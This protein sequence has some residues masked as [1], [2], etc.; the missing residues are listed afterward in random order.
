M[1]PNEN[2]V[3]P[4]RIFQMAWGYAPPLILEAAIRHRI[5]DMLDGGPKSLSQLQK[6]TGASERGLSA[7][8][9]ALVALNLLSKDGQGRF[10]LTPESAA[11]LVSSKPSF[12]GGLLRHTSQDLIPKWLQLNEIVATG[13]PAQ[14]VNQK[15]AGIEFFRKFVNDIFPMSYP[16]AQ[17][18]ARH[19]ETEG[20]RGAVRVL[21]LGAGS[22]VWGIGLAQGSADL[23]VTALDWPDVIQVTRETVARFGLSDR[24]SYIEGDLL[25]AQFGSDY[26]VVTIGQILHSEGV[27][28]SR[29]LLAKSFQALAPGG[30]IAIAEFLVNADRTGPVSSLLFAVNM[31]VNTERGGTY[32]FEEIA[33]WL[34]DVGFVNPRTIDSPGPSPLVLANKP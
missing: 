21:D 17:F 27:D 18:L 5:F 32:S 3:T 29:A 2:S 4:E 13:K 24:F 20:M 12:Q 16:A 28:R 6:D 22:G 31:L 25:E 1:T 33:G 7:I 19:L 9:N 34:S 11:F 14:S 30:T 10:S 26:N 23:H 15:E 8:A